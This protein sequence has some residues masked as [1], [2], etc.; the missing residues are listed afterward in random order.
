VYFASFAVTALPIAFIC[1]HGRPSAVNSFF[2]I[3]VLC[4]QIFRSTHLPGFD[5]RLASF[6]RRPRHG[7]GPGRLTKINANF[8]GRF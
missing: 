8:H 7:Q 3:I 6:Y 4:D 1:V 2:V 5:K